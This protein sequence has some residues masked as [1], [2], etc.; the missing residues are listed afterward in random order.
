[1]HQAGSTESILR[2]ALRSPWAFRF[3]LCQTLTQV[4]SFLCF[5]Y[6]SVRN[7]WTDW[8]P[9]FLYFC[10]T[11][12]IIFAPIHESSKIM[13]E[14]EILWDWGFFQLRRIVLSLV[15]CSESS[16]LVSSAFIFSLSFDLMPKGEVK[17]ETHPGH[18]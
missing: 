4:S 5:A 1:M 16:E 10:I 6:I 18:M 13:F 7:S 8:A 17:L 11:I 9:F 15:W 12:S 3:F 14:N 2:I